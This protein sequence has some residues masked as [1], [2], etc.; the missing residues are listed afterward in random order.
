MKLNITVH[1]R[2]GFSATDIKKHEEACVFLAEILNSVEF[3]YAVLTA[4]FSTTKQ[5]SLQVYD[6]IISGSE[7]LDMTV[8]H[9]LDIYVELYY[10]NNRTV[11]YTMPSTP[12]T[13]LNEKFF[14]IFSAADVARNLFHEWLHKCGFD[15]SSANDLSSVPYQL[16]NIIGD[17]IKTM[18]KGGKLTP[19]KFEPYIETVELP[20]IEIKPKV[21]VCFRSWRTWFMK[22]CVYV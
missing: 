5:T 13:W 2:K 16:G 11:G 20:P 19:D 6:R 1:S 18:V 10:K 17:L 4:K 22:R 15:H 14:R 21:L 9:E 3:K 7:D 8:D 12:W